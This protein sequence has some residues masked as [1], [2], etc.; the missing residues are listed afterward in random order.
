[1][2]INLPPKLEELVRRK[3]ESG[4]YR[5]ESDVVG[6]AL[7]QMA[8]SDAA[9][10]AKLERLRQALVSGEQ[11]GFV[12]DFSMDRLIEE[13]EEEERREALAHG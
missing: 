1:M 4:E 2:R 9:Y 3:V 6:E 8:A 10:E 13:I 12:E 7:R 11:S 5:D